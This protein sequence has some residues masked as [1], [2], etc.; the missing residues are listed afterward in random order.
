MEIDGVDISQY[1]TDIESERIKNNSILAK[2]VCEATLDGKYLV[3]IGLLNPRTLESIREFL[4][5]GI[6]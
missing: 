6:R 3:K 2:K 4:V 5:D 1:L